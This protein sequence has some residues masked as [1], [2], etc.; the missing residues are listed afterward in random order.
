M[1]GGG[2]SN[3]AAGATADFGKAI[4]TVGTGLTDWFGQLKGEDMW[5]MQQLNP[6]ISQMLTNAF[7]PQQALYGRTLQQVTD[8][9]R[10]GEAA[11]GVANTPYGAAAEGNALS[12]F[13]IDWQNQQLQ[14]EMAGLGSAG[15]TYQQLIGAGATAAQPAE[16]ALQG[17]ASAYNTS[18][19]ASTADLNRQAQQ[20]EAGMQQIGSL[21]SSLIGKGGGG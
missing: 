5:A 14:R 4:G 10:S 6:D 13:N 8:Q 15:N 20:Q 3:P 12:N 18:S 17:Y 11:R 16:A 2:G 1:G 19:Q 21:A 7:D 9:T